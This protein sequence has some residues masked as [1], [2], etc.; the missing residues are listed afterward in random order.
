M[1][2]AVALVLGVGTVFGVADQRMSIKCHVRTDLVGASGLEVHLQ[3][4]GFPVGAQGA[5]A[6]DDGLAAG[7]LIFKDAHL[8]SLAV[9][10]QKVAQGPA[11]WLH[12]AVYQAQVELGQLAVLHLLVE[13]AQ[14]LRSW[15]P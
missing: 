3:Q 6:G 8:I 11:F 4:A 15:R 2:V 12:H 9:L 7:H 13:D 1:V 10:E 14:R 5:V